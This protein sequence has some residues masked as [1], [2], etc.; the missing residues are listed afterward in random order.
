MNDTMIF[1]QG[2]S[3]V[4]EAKETVQLQH[5]TSHLTIDI[6]GH[7]ILDHDLNPQTGENRL[8]DAPR[9]AIS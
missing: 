6:M 2:L 9:Q 4:A 8:V 5:M 3:W 7:V 1:W